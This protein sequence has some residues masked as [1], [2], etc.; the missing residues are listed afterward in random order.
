MQNNNPQ[1]LHGSL[2]STSSVW[3]ARDLCPPEMRH[4][5]DPIYVERVV[6]DANRHL[7][8][9]FVARIFDRIWKIAR[10][11]SNGVLKLDMS[12]VMTADAKF[13]R[14]LGYF[15]RQQ[16]NRGFVL[17]VTNWR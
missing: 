12:D 6:P 8:S 16:R 15:R 3:S 9:Q 2:T 5:E 11:R 7:N 13:E 17:R 4:I 1:A 14:E 10:K